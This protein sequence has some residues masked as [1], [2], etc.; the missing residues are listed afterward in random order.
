[1]KG[2]EYLETLGK[3]KGEGRFTP[4]TIRELLSYFNNPQDSF[5]SIH[6]AGTNG[7]GSTSTLCASILG[8]AGY[9][10]GLTVSP[11]FISPTERIIIDGKEITLNYLNQILEKIQIVAAREDLTLTYHE[12]LTA[13]AFIAFCEAKCDWGV[14]EVGL[15]GKLDSTNVLKEPKAIIITSIG[16][17]HESI[18]GNSIRLIAKEKAGII[19]KGSKVI[20][21]AMDYEALDSILEEVE[22]TKSKAYAFGKDF[23]CS[24]H[25]NLFEYKDSNRSFKI[26]PTYLNSPYQASNIGV[27][28]KACTLLGLK[29]ESIAE[30]IANAFLPCRFELINHDDSEFILDSAHNSQAFHSLKAS[31]T[32]RNIEINSAIFGVLHTKNWKEMCKA[33]S[34]ITSQIALV[35][36]ES[37]SAAS[38]EEVAQ[39]LSGFGVS[40][41]RFGKDY[42][43]ALNFCKQNG[44]TLVCG[45]M[46]F[47]GPVRRLLGVGDKPLWIRNKKI[48]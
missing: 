47:L 44:R 35:T 21:G 2:I 7:K 8:S 38:E 18:L 13:A 6:V 5:S 10:V 25:D 31:L 23:S 24:F 28:S 15:G 30:G 32:T 34:S 19:K 9:K 4:D 33:L 42:Q 1:M 14:I 45:S 48:Q 27:A 20:I 3:W 37:D 46:Y 26:N 41:N 29:E 12:A 36:P 11:H 40:V 16:L 43:A 17:D 39:I 22:N